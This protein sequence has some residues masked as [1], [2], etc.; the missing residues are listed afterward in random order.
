VKIP[1]A[2]GH[3]EIRTPGFNILKRWHTVKFLGKRFHAGEAPCFRVLKVDQFTECLN[4]RGTRNSETAPWTHVIHILRDL[5]NIFIVIADRFKH[6]PAE[7]ITTCHSGYWILVTG[8]F[9]QLARM[10]SPFI[11]LITSSEIPFG[12]TASHSPILVH[13]PKDSMVIWRT[14]RNARESLSG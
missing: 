5:F 6:E 13:W 12:H 10:K 1:T 9:F 11:R 4:N 2:L 7:Q 3:P 8:Y 14:I